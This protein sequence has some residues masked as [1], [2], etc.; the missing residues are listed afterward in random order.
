MK[1]IPILILM[2]FNFTLA[3]GQ[4]VSFDFRNTT[5]AE[6]LTQLAAAT[7]EYDI[8]CVTSELD[9][10]PVSVRIR[11]LSIP[12]AVARVTKGQPVKVKTKGRRIIVQYSSTRKPR[13]LKLNGTVN[14]TRAHN[15]LLGATVDLL[16]EDSTLIHSLT[17]T[18]RYSSDIGVTWERSEFTFSVPAVPAKYI[19]RISL[20]GYQTTY[21]DYALEHISRRELARELPPFYLQ[22]QAVVMKE[23]TVT[24]SRVRFYYKGD[25]IVYNADAFQLA[26]GSMLDELLRQIPGMEM[27][28]DGRIYHNGKFVD[29][30][31]L[32]GKAFFQGD[33][34]LLLENLPAYTVKDIAIYNKQTEENEWLG[35]KDPMTQRY[36][37]D[38]RLKK[39]YMVGWVANIEA[40][41]GYREDHTPYLARLFAMRHT[42]HSRITLIGNAN[43]LDDDSHP[44][45]KNQWNGGNSGLRRTELAAVE[46]NIESRDKE[47]SYGGYATAKHT[48]ERKEQTTA[49]Q[50]FLASGDTYEHRFSNN[51]N[52]D[53]R[54]TAFQ[55]L[56]YKNERLMLKFEP[57]VQYRRYCNTA[58]SVSASFT[59]PVAEVSRRLLDNLFSPTSS[60]PNLRDT[61][62]NRQ[63]RESL[64]TGHDLD[65]DLDLW[66]TL[67]L[68]NSNDVLRFAID[69]RYYERAHQLFSRQ[70]VKYAAAPSQPQGAG[71]PRTLFRH[72]LADLPPSRKWEMHGMI[73][74][75]LPLGQGWR[76]LFTFYQY[77]HVDQHERESLYRLDQ[78]PSADSSFARPIGELPSLSEYRH[79][80]DRTNSHRSHYVDNQHQFVANV[81]YEFDKKAYGTAYLLFDARVDITQQRMDYQRGTIDTVLHRTAPTLRFAATPWIRFTNGSWIQFA[82]SI[83]IRQPD[84]VNKAAIRDDSDPMNVRLGNPNLR[85]SVS[86]SYGLTYS[87]SNKKRH[88]ANMLSL[89]YSPT[90][91]AIAMGQTYDC[92][93]GVRTYRPD[94]I[95]GNWDAS[96]KHELNYNFT[97][98]NHN[99]SV[100]SRLAYQHSVDLMGE[101]APMRSVVRT[102]SFSIAPKLK[103]TLGKHTLNFTAEASANR[104]T[105]HRAD[106]QDMTATNY[107]I[108][109]DAILHL[110]WKLDLTTDL[111]LYGRRGYAD[112]LMNTDDLVWNARLSRPFAKGRLLL[113]IDGF[114][115]LGQL[116]NV[117]RTVN[118]QGRTETWTNVMPRYVLFHAVWRL[119]KEPKKP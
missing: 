79:T 100:S 52:E 23:V 46:V 56:T 16:S 42:D 87:K 117:T 62:I 99:L 43:N 76:Q 89:N 57:N 81:G 78:L 49:T 13:I 66:G 44:D 98:H 118:A 59:A 27:K 3:F 73:G 19:F 11:N 77:L 54:L 82:P 111:T 9:S 34:K 51:R 88:T 14:D 26:E 67:K 114:D 55:H 50:N 115:L 41:S 71:S 40:G 75:T 35:K 91:R 93:T 70:Q 6:A 39:E 28:S 80:L 38:V 105:S 5:L 1:R 95:N 47:W 53:W 116:S 8:Q 103:F 119:N 18:R 24:A 20:D 84:L 45:S 68:K 21:V 90:F 113:M 58:N 109:A 107:R 7:S 48:T 2:A 92:T 22:K 85:S 61:L 110:P 32:N 94:N 12:D 104:Y 17:A 10:L 31:L 36:V 29:D 74:Y 86:T 64:G 65:A 25:T 4:A 101:E 97:E 96:M 112:R 108:G 106:F 83:D 102:L 15:Q 60:R 37:I 63:L 30:L 69:G 72:Q 33:R